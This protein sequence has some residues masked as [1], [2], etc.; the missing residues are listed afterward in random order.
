MGEV[1]GRRAWGRSGPEAGGT[2][3]SP[4]RRGQAVRSGAAA[5]IRTRLGHLRF[6]IYET[7][8]SAALQM[9][10]M[11]A[12]ICRLAVVLLIACSGDENRSE[13]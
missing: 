13:Q 12:L 10:R 4:G 2:V 1:R 9:R 3:R 7:R 8:P 6:M 11:N 5:P